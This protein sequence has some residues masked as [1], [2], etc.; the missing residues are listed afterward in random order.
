[1]ALFAALLALQISGSA[2]TPADADVLVARA[3]AARYQQDSALASYQVIVRQRMSAGIGLAR[4]FSAVTPLAVAAAVGRERLAARF[5]SVARVGWHRET[6]AWAEI[7]GSRNVMPLLGESVPDPEELDEDV[8]LVLPHAP[9]RDRL[10]PIDEMRK[11]LPQFQ[12]W[13][14][15]PLAAGADSLYLVSVGDSLQ[16]RLP[17]GDQLLLIELRVEPRRP[18]SRLIVGSLWIDSET[19]SLVRAAYRPSVPID[20]WPFIYREIGANDRDKV[21]RFGPFTG[22]IKEIVVEHAL[23]EGRFWLPRARVASAEGTARGARVSI[24]IQQTFAYERVTA[25]A[26]MP[27]P[28][29]PLADVDPRTGRVRQPKWFGVEQRTRTC[30]E[31]GDSSSAWL[32]ESWDVETLNLMYAEGIRFRVLIPCE[33]EDM[34]ASPLLPPSIYSADD[35]LFTETDL[36]ALRKDVEGALGMSRQSRW[37]PQPWTVQYGIEDGL[38]RY[39]RVEGLSAGARV[40]RILGDGYA[41]QGTA[42]L[43]TADLEPN[44]ELLGWRTNSARTVGVG[45]YRRLVAAN[46]WGSPLGLGASV[47]AL[48]FGKDEGFYYRALGVEIGGGNRGATGPSHTWRAFLERHDSASVE[49]HASLARLLND[50]RFPMNISARPATYW[51]LAGSLQATGGSDPRGTRVASTTRAEAAMSDVRGGEHARLMTEITVVRGIGDRWSATITGGAGASAGTLPTQRLWYLGGAHTV[52][53]H[54]AGTAAG[55]AFWLARSE[56]AFGHPL[57]RPAIFFD[58]GWAGDRRQWDSPGKPL[59]GVGIGASALDGLLRLDVSRGL[60]HDRLTR[61]DFYFELR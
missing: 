56:L 38:L 59:T 3:R 18:E 5:E 33:R 46:D 15:H 31:R 19:G 49:T 35:E 22:I 39:N 24:S 25:G 10:W 61:L 20:L 55:D 54:R 14:E 17:N 45:A 32:P 52:R 47:N 6:G 40:S 21:E 4:G 28:L 7:L 57:V 11:A 27:P 58:V 42:R 8:A 37:S 60:T 2:A 51:G 43:G 36:D 41:L 13:I 23:H 50:R 30:R 29:A 48:L 34:I 44:V 53:G 12:D 16:F 1:M 26:P 9:G